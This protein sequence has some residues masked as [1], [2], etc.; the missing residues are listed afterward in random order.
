MDDRGYERHGDIILFWRLEHDPDGEDPVHD[1]DAMGEIWTLKRHHHRFDEE[2]VLEALHHNPDAVQLSYDEHGLCSWHVATAHPVPGVEYV[3]DGRRVAGVWLPD[4]S[5][6]E[7]AEGLDAE[8]RRAK[9]VEWAGQ[10]CE[11]YT[12]WCNGECF[13]Y[14]VVTY[15]VRED[16]GNL[17]NRRGDYRFQTPLAED[18]LAGLIGVEY[19]EG[20]LEDA[21]R[22]VLEQAQEARKR[23]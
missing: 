16:N 17:Y 22:A 15:R 1:S 2:K 14:H 6:L 5:L 10:A 9:M 3:W 11:A 7:E 23:P 18:S 4:K 13:V 20:E 19:A 8:A 21:K 12:Q